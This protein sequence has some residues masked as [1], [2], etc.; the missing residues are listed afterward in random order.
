MWGG[1]AA[2]RQASIRYFVSKKENGGFTSIGEQEWNMIRE[3]QEMLIGAMSIRSNQRFS[4][5]CEI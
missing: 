4:P 1:G 2:C 5:V 3:K